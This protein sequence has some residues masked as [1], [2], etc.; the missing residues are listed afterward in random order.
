MVNLHFKELLS[1]STVLGEAP[2]SESGAPTSPPP[3]C[4]ASGLESAELT[5]RTLQIRTPSFQSG[6]NSTIETLPT[7]VIAKNAI[8]MT[9]IYSSGELG[10]AGLH[11]RR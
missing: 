10:L 4:V 6:A 2:T 7:P 9:P 11:Q 1:G 3:E 5:D 8:G